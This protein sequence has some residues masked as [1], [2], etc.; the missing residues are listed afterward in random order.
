MFI[1]E[2]RGR[3]VAKWGGD[4]IS[5]VGRGRLPWRSGCGGHQGE[6]IQLETPQGGGKGSGWHCHATSYQE[7]SAQPQEMA[8]PQ[9]VR[10]ENRWPEVWES[11]Q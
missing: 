7:G 9:G 5:P 8:A 3:Q 2:E 1:G 11:L 6:G 10:M 4:S